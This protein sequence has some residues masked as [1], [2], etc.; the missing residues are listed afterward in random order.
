MD[1][2]GDYSAL[3][4]S[5]PYELQTCF[6]SAL[7]TLRTWPFPR[8]SSTSSIIAIV[9]VI[10]FIAIDSLN[11]QH[12]DN[13]DIEH[14]RCIV[15]SHATIAALEHAQNSPR[16]CFD[17]ISHVHHIRS[18][19]AFLAVN[20]AKLIVPDAKTSEDNE[21]VFWNFDSRRDEPIKLASEVSHRAPHRHLVLR[22]DQK[23]E[24]VDHMIP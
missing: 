13:R 20:T 8:V 16:D 18:I 11:M 14:G 3:S 24:I 22:R 2:A 5:Q 23:G 17:H 7:L 9:I 21:R 19:I 4:G 10:V 6:Q 15:P 1:T 12:F